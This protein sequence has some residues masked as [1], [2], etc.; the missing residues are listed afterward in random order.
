MYSRYPHLK[1]IHPIPAEYSNYLNGKKHG[2]HV[3]FFNKDSSVKSETKYV[4]GIRHG[5]SITYYQA[6]YAY[7]QGWRIDETYE[8]DILVSSTKY[9]LW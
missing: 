6:E 5:H 9:D 1:N 4:N 8:H 2:V 3:F 7:T